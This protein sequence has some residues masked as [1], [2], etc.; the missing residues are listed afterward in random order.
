MT[1]ATIPGLASE[2][3]VSLIGVGSYLP[4]RRVSNEEILEIPPAR[5]P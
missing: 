5:P 4:E 3:S 1:N 2:V